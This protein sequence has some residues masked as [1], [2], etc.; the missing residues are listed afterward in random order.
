MK[1][2]TNVLASVVSTQ[3][4]LFYKEYSAAGF[5][6]KCA[7]SG[8]HFCIIPTKKDHCPPAFQRKNSP[9]PG[10]QTTERWTDF[11]TSPR[12][13]LPVASLTS[14]SRDSRASIWIKISFV[15]DIITGGG[16]QGVR[17]NRVSGVV[18]PGSCFSVGLG[19]DA[20]GLC[21][22]L[23]V[24]HARRSLIN[25]VDAKWFRFFFGKWTFHYFR[26]DGESFWGRKGN[27]KDNG[28]ESFRVIIAFH[29]C[30]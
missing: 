26:V 6:R 23:I 17:P 4:L 29:Y 21:K 25:F 28:N 20:P 7:V 10:T 30:L 3:L 24:R 14:R 27:G 8:N 9:N 15:S 13:K 1:R 5:H 2:L 12:T 11:R 19:S 18:E 22:Q 16:E